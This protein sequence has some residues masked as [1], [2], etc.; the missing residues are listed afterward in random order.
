MVILSMGLFATFGGAYLGAK[1]A[2]QI[3]RDNMIDE[4]QINREIELERMNLEYHLNQ[5][6][7]LH[8]KTTI[9]YFNI[10]KFEKKL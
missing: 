8:E 10:N 5:L 6:R 7:Y 2:G 3:S 9:L 1:I 4:L